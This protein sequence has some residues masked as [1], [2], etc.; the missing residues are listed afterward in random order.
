MTLPFLHFHTPHL[1]N[2]PDSQPVSPHCRIPIP[3]ADH[4]PA[5]LVRPKQYT[6]DTIDDWFPFSAHNL[7]L[8]EHTPTRYLPTK[9]ATTHSTPEIYPFPHAAPTTTMVPF[10]TIHCQ[11]QAS[12]LPQNRQGKLETGPSTIPIPD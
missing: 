3:H 7:A 2:A 5:R 6:L 4:L 10:R 12:S 9:T 8:T 1:R 11:K